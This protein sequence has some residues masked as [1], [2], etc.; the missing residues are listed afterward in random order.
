M[1]FP[2]YVRSSCSPLLQ[3][4]FSDAHHII[5]QI[6]ALNLPRRS[7]PSSVAGS[8]FSSCFSSTQWSKWHKKCRVRH[9]HINQGWF[10]CSP[11]IPWHGEWVGTSMWRFYTDGCYFLEIPLPAPQLASHLSASSSS[12][13][14]LQCLQDHLG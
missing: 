12:S 7:W 6:S 9:C 3:A 8:G 5:L 13:L 11:G 14:W 4:V 1:S 10:L 2:G